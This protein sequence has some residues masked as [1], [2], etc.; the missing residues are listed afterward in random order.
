M[1]DEHLIT[2]GR[3]VRKL[4][5]ERGI[6]QEAFAALVGIDRS[7]MGRIERGENNVTLTRIYQISEA[8]NTSPRQLFGLMEE[9]SVPK[10]KEI[11]HHET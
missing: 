8:L 7:Y 5:E 11:Q 2:F 6:S 1:T 4:R 10:S 9:L 3:A